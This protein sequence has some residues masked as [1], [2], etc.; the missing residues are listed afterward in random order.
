MSRADWKLPNGTVTLPADSSRL[1][2]L[3]ERRNGVGG[4]DAAAIMGVHVS[5]SVDDVY[6]QKMDSAEPVESD[7]PVLAFGHAL[8]P[9]LVAEVADRHSVRTRNVGL[10]RAKS[11]RWRY[12]SPDGLTSDGGVLECKTAGRRTEAAEQWAAGEI[13]GH[14]YVQGQHY[15]MVTGRSHLYYSVGIRNDYAPWEEVPR[16]WWG[17]EWFRSL[18]LVDSFVTG[19]V[20]RDEAF[21]DE[22]FAAEWEFWRAVLEGDVPPAGPSSNAAGRTVDR[23]LPGSSVEAL[24]PDLVVGAREELRQVKTRQAELAKERKRLESALKDE[25]GEAEFLTADGVPIARWRNVEA[26]RLDQKSLKA[27]H[28]ELVADYMRPSVSRRFELT[29]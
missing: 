21:I 28:P 2:W 17:T 5:A 29:D 26:V 27:D 6:L 25:M 24:I 12:A 8:E 3:R 20:D 18:A 9:F 15:L 14:A 22:L 1:T 4:T 7:A 19:R 13:P 11:D 23:A 10:V 16:R